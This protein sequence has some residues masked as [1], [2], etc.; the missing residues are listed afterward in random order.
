MSE[1]PQRCRWAPRRARRQRTPPRPFGGGHRYLIAVAQGVWGQGG[2]VSE[3]TLEMLVGL[4]VGRARQLLAIVGGQPFVNDRA[5]VARHHADGDDAVDAP[6]ILHRQV[7]VVRRETVCTQPSRTPMRKE[8]SSDVHHRQGFSASTTRSMNT[9][10]RAAASGSRPAGV[11]SP[12]GAATR[13]AIASPVP[14]GAGTG[15]REAL[16]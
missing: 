9:D 3:P 15:G 10:K 6:A 11:P 14:W 4:G 12:I 7:R 16:G 2:E 1:S 8:V 5:G 13:S